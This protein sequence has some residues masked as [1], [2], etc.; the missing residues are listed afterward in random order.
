MTIEYIRLS[1]GEQHVTNEKQL[2]Y[3]WIF[4]F[5]IG[6]CGRPSVVIQEDQLRMLYDMNYTAP[7]MATHFGCSA[8]LIYK[9][10]YE[11]GLK[12]RERY[13]TV[14][15]TEL[16]EKVQAL[17]TRFPNAGSVHI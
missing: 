13:T 3:C 4:F 14:T 2:V 5:T 11:V 12:L 6:G 7:Q 15:N 8:Q 1:P 16:D 17:Q 10:L 9:R